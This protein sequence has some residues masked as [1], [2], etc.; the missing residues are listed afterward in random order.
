MKA[1]LIACLIALALPAHAGTKEG[2]DSCDPAVVRA[3]AEEVLRDPATLKEPLMLYHPALGLALTGQNEQAAL[4]YLTARLRTSRH[5]V[6]AAG[7]R[8]QLLGVMEMTISPLVMS[9]LWNDPALARRLVQRVIE[10]DRATP[11]PTRNSEAAKSAEI[12]KK[13]A[14]ID[15]AIARFPDQ[16]RDD[17]NRAAKALAMDTEAKRQMKPMVAERCRSRTPGVLN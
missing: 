9:T 6:V 10:W 3:A 8:N 15:A 12:Q 16:I 13:L 4:M 11:D 7:D 2:L 17:P 14:Q 5:A 1:I